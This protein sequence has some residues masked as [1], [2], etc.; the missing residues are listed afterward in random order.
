MADK[1]EEQK[2][3]EYIRTSFENAK[4]NKKQIMA[5]SSVLTYLFKAYEGKTL[6]MQRRRM[7]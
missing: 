7:I 2:T 1:L 5:K 6:D 4:G 3:I